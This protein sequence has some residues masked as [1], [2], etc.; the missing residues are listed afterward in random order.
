MAIAV[1]FSEKNQPY[2]RHVPRVLLGELGAAKYAM[3]VTGKP[4]CCSGK[5]CICEIQRALLK[6]T[7][8]EGRYLTE[9][10]FVRE[11]NGGCHLLL[12]KCGFDNTKLE[13]IRPM[14]RMLGLR[15]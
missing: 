6:V 9:A 15:L 4:P 12:R 7:R 10:S 13:G 5:S 14:M 2:T 3:D 1:Y 11:F 8:M